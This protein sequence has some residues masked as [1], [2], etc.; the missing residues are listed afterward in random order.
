MN[1]VLFLTLIIFISCGHHR[2]VRPGVNGVNSVSVIGEDK[3]EISRKALDQSQ[4]YCDSIGQRAA[5]KS[6]VIKFVGSGSEEDYKKIKGVTKA[7]QVAGSGAYVFGGKKERNAGGIAGIGAAA[8][9]AY[10]GDGYQ[11]TMQFI[12][13]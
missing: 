4:H 2:D 10:A 3:V 1:K 8:A 9:S 13:K 6:E 12:C 11:V 7:V 5:I